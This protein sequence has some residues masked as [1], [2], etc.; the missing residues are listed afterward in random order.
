MNNFQFP[1]VISQFYRVKAYRVVGADFVRHSWA[2]IFKNSLD[3][4]ENK[5]Y[6]FIFYFYFVEYISM[7]C[8]VDISSQL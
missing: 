7:S 3:I 2:Q 1:R 4:I 5:V 6:L 8:H